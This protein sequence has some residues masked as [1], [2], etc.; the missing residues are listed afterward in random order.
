M[1]ANEIAVPLSAHD[2]RP[3]YYTGGAWPYGATDAAMGRH[4][5]RQ[6]HSQDACQGTVNRRVTG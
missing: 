6:W 3:A 2:C 4:V 5:A 1:I